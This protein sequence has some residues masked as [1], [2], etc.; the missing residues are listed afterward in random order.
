MKVVR[1]ISTN[2]WMILHFRKWNKL[3]NFF[4][5]VPELVLLSLHQLLVQLLAIRGSF[6]TKVAEWRRN[7][8]ISPEIR[9]HRYFGCIYFFV[10]M[11]FILWVHN[12][13]NSLKNKLWQI[14][15]YFGVFFLCVR[16]YYYY[17]TATQSI[18][19]T[20]NFSPFCLKTSD[21]KL[22]M[23][24]SNAIHLQWV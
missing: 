9:V 18:F 21:K 2:A 4:N 15:K 19:A 5:F 22:N 6:L 14:Q 20:R 8:V 10:N 3:N 24:I 7:N 17:Q 13:S 12:R 23:Y 16:F 1:V 11:K